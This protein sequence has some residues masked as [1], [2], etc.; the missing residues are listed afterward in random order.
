MEHSLPAARFGFALASTYV[1][2]N[3][4]SALRH[5]IPEIENELK[6]RLFDPK[7]PFTNTEGIV[8]QQLMVDCLT[9]LFRLNSRN[10][11]WSLYPVCLDPEAPPIFKLVLLKSCLQIAGEE[12]R[13]P[14]NPTISAT[15]TNLTS[16][17]R[18]LF[19]EY[20][21]KSKERV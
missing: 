21:A 4:M 12:N 20:L 16:P 5:L 14:W 9:A 6:D 3:D 13:L 11:I 7:K 1:S 17:L 15:Y 2:K 18:K 10:V 19:Q 8:D